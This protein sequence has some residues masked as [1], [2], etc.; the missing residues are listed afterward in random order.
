MCGACVLNIGLTNE[1]V[2]SDN[3]DIHHIHHDVG[4]IKDKTA[5][6]RGR[7]NVDQL[8]SQLFGQLVSC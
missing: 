3:T 5:I 1:K 7:L 2:L 4:R 8:V 6:Y